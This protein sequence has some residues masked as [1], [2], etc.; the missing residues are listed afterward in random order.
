MAILVAGVSAASLGLIYL[1]IAVSILA[2]TTLAVGV[3]LR[4]RE[5]FGE[6]EAAPRSPEP[7]W[8]AAEPAKARPVPV[9]P[10]AGDRVTADHGGRPGD[11]RH[12]GEQQ[13][14]VA[15]LRRAGSGTA[16]DTGSARWP[17]SIAAKGTPA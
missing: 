15:R 7:G 6:A 11:N 17:A 14:D 13:G 16:A 9:W 2:A 4:R 1:A 5:I 12:E 8:A 3:L 10:A